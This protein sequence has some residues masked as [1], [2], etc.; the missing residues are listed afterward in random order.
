ALALA[1]EAAGLAST[2]LLDRD[3]ARFAEASRDMA[4]R[5]D[6]IVPS[7]NGEPR[8]HKPILIYWLMVGSF[9][10]LGATELAARIPSVLST[11]CLVL[12]VHEVGLLLR[13][14][15]AGVLA[16]LLTLASPLV[17]FEG[18]IGTADAAL[19]ASTT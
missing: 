19:A 9:A 2:P 11:A 12:L 6:L 15:R 13:G 10:L 1:I 16:A 4:A 5:G 8:Y 17:W 14:R 3:E 7:F 18:R